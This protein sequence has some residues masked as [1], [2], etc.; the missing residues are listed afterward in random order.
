M[1]QDRSLAL[2]AL[3]LTTF[4]QSFLRLCCIF[5][6]HLSLFQRTFHFHCQILSVKTLRR[7]WNICACLILATAFR[8]SYLGLFLLLTTIFSVFLQSMLIHFFLLF[9]T[10]QSRNYCSFHLC[11]CHSRGGSRVVTL[12]PKSFQKLNLDTIKRGKILSSFL[13]IQKELYQIVEI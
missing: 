9:F 5:G 2:F 10:P 8:T 3:F 12:I 1:M 6:R 7:C 4:R 11:V 13:G